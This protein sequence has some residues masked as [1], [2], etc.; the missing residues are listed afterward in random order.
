MKNIMSLVNLAIC[1]ACSAKIEFD[2]FVKK[3]FLDSLFPAICRHPRDAPL[4]KN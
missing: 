1:R 3:P 4:K 2:D